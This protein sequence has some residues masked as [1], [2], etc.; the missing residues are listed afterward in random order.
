MWI[1]GP[2]VFIDTYQSTHRSFAPVYSGH[3]VCWDMKTFCSSV[4]QVDLKHEYRIIHAV[5]DIMLFS[6]FSLEIDVSACLLPDILLDYV[7]CMCR[8]I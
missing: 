4:L 7:Q 5:H 1:P 8:R 2:R 6:I 3:F